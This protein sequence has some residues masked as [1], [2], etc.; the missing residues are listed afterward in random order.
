MERSEMKNPDDPRVRIIIWIL[1]LRKL[2]S[3]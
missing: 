1:P 2:R 3:E